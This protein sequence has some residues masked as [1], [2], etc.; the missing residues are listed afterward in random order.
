MGRV[1]D[2]RLAPKISRK[3]PQ[4]SDL[5]FIDKAFS[6]HVILFPLVEDQPILQPLHLR[7]FRWRSRYGRTLV[8]RDS[9]GTQ[10]RRKGFSLTVRLPNPVRIEVRPDPDETRPEFGL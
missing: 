10:A 2:L 1:K 7:F 5:S 9:K 6:G 4:K 3:F 8:Q